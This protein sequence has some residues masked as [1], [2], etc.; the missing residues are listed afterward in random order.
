M[1]I[2]ITSTFENAKEY[3]LRA[4]QNEAQL[5]ELWQYYMIDPF[6]KEISK[7]APFDQ[8]VKK[9]LLIKDLSALKNQLPLLSTISID[10]LRS[11]FSAVTKALT[12]TEDS[13][14]MPVFLYPACNSDKILKERQNGIVG[15][16]VF[17][18]MIIRINPLA[19]DYR[20]W[21]PYVFAHEYHHN[22][23]GYIHYV[24]HGGRDTDGSFLEYMII[25]GQ[26]DSFAESLF[27]GLLPQ[28]NRPFDE[29]T[30]ASLWEQIQPVLLSNNSQTHSLYMFGDKSRGLPW[31]MGY[32]FGRMIV[33]DY[34]SQHPE[35]SFTEL[36]HIPAGEIFRSSRFCTTSKA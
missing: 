34:L 25:E 17:G 20:R 7:W 26:A 8:S 12:L 3:L 36:I 27:P 28:W 31:C 10:D 19:R 13:E 6:W 5:S 32:S 23:W 14:P 24:L 4:T 30:E 16:V 33:S 2:K 11:E 9:P 15:A 35:V 18:S 21:I 29:K 22:I 1:N